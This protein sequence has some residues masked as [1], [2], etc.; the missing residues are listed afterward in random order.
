MLN[1]KCQGWF[2]DA[3][4]T[5]RTSKDEEK[6]GPLF[7]SLLFLGLTTFLSPL[8]LTLSFSLSLFSPSKY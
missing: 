4:M 2:N 8:S 3:T 6:I 7:L 5:R 1:K